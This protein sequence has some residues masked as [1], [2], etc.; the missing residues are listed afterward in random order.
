MIFLF[1]G[2]NIVFL[3]AAVVFLIFL[4]H[5]LVVAPYR[6]SPYAPTRQARRAAIFELA[7]GKPGDL[8]V[9]LG[10]GNGAVLIAAASRGIR[11]RGVEINPFWVW[12]SRRRIARRGLGRLATVVRGD[13]FTH[14]VADADIIFMYLV[15]AAMERLAARLQREAMPGTR[16][17]AH[18][19]L[20]PGWAPVKE[21]DKVI[22]Y[23]A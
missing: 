5:T 3:A 8:L 11:A 16:I 10:S 20:L 21:R 4:T 19:F 23:H 13:M 7:E 17:I 12:Y 2:V 9:D 1:L 15:P 18:C 14:P 6:G 22:L